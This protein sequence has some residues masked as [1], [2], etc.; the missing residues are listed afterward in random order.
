M[1]GTQTS[2]FDVERERRWHIWVLFAVLFAITFAAVWVVTFSIGNA[3]AIVLFDTRL[4]WLTLTGPGLA[5]LLLG[6]MGVAWLYWRLSRIG[7][8]QRLL[9]AMC[10]RPLDPDDRYH[11][12]LRNIV[13]EMAIAGGCSGLRCVVV[14]TMGMNAFAFSDFDNGGTIGVTEGALAR[15][16]RQQLEA[17]VAH[18]MAHILAGDCRTVTAACL[19]FGVYSGALAGFAAT[20]VEA[21]GSRGGPDFAPVALVLHVGFVFVLTGTLA[22]L[23][24]AST[25]ISSAVSRQRE[26]RADAAAVR[27]T[28]DPLSLAQALAMMERHP[29][30]AGHIAAGLAALCI[31]STESGAW[32]WLDRLSETHPPTDRRIAA[33]LA[34]AGVSERQFAA[35][36]F[37][38]EDALQQRE[39]FSVPR[40]QVVAPLAAAVAA[41]LA[42]ADGAGG[43]SAFA[44]PRGAEQAVAATNVSAVA[45]AGPQCPACGSTLRPLEYEGMTV[46]ACSGCGGRL[47]PGRA[48]ARILARREVGFTDEQR[49][50]AADTAAQGDTLRR[51]AV[52]SRGRH[53]SP[54]TPCPVCGRTMMRRH[55][56][57]QYAV[58]VDVCLVCDRFWFEKDE[59]EV[60]QLLVE[61]Q[62]D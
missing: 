22:L 43:A 2:F 52:L 54:L 30:G 33:L 38:A 11:Q 56:D 6:S 57:L 59:L 29:G 34:F 55:Y 15:L 10:A 8:E 17:V 9:A 39:H 4:F 3:A 44:G 24:L 60:L 50:K 62:V 40:E 23:A 14:P 35:S 41:G 21:E 58:E 51:A 16:T 7:A 61:G 27:Y 12:R 20:D 5:A 32:G 42:V 47:V 13:D 48:M 53:D 31:R 36:A 26:Y 45:K 18:E 19:L 25:L 37:A 28:R 1:D 49:L 46:L